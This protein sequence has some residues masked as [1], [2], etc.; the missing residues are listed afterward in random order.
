MRARIGLRALFLSLRG[1]SLHEGRSS[2]SLK[3]KDGRGVE[4][5]D[6]LLV[7]RG[8]GRRGRVRRLLLPLINHLSPSILSTLSLFSTEHEVSS[9]DIVESIKVITA[10]K[11]RRTCEYAFGYAFLNGRPKVTA[12]H[13]ANIM[14]LGDGMFL[15]EFRAAAARWASRGVAAEEMIVDN[16][17]MQ[18]SSH[19]EQFS[20]GVCVSPNLYGNLLSNIGN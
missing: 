14:K 8:L 11:S 10:E 18:M 13:K 4:R 16:A 20:G 2:L 12:I 19:P 15:R 17:C 7:A 9:P 1:L 5:F 3:G 6:F